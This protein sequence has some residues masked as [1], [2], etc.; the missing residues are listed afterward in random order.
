M[1]PD[2]TD[3]RKAMPLTEDELYLAENSYGYGNW[4]AKYWVVGL[5]ERLSPSDRGDRTK[6]ADAFRKLNKD[7]LCD[8]IDFH[9]EIGEDRWLTEVQHTWGRLIWLLKNYL[10]EDLG[11]SSLLCYQNHHWGRT[12]GDTCIT[13]LSGLPAD[14]SVTG[15]ALDRER[16]K[17]CKRQLDEI[18]MKR[19]EEL[20]RKIQ[21]YEPE[22]VVFYGLGQT[23]GKYWK[24]IARTELAYDDVVKAGKTA[25]VWSPHPNTHGRRKEKWKDLGRKLAVTIRT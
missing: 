14:S 2:P 1:S 25:F 24:D 18:R 7:G 3:K 13:E 12:N 22:L 17:D 15:R 16:F 6:R 10:K 5:E 11:Y 20:G 23:Q 19:I 8:L 9:R 4:E 21:K